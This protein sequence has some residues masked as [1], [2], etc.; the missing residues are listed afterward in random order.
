MR[1]AR[2]IRN[3]SYQAYGERRIDRSNEADEGFGT[4]SRKRREQQLAP[5]MKMRLVARW[6]IRVH[7]AFDSGVALVA[8]CGK[9]R[10]AL[11][12]LRVAILLLHRPAFRA[13]R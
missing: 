12:A 11:L 1:G 5:L 6:R 13:A 2:E 3:E 4:Y 8:I 9:A 10:L 7:R